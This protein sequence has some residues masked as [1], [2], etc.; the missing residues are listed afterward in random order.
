MKTNKILKVMSIIL[1]LIIITIIAFVG[2]YV[3]DNGRWENVI[4]DFTLGSEFGSQREIIFSVDDNKKDVYYDKKGNR[5]LD[6]DVDKDAKEG[7]YDIKKEDINAEDLKTTDNFIKTKEM[8][9]NRINEIGVEEYTIT[10]D[11]K[12][13]DVVLKT[14]DNTQIDTMVYGMFGKGNFAIKDAETQN[15][16]LSNE[17]LNNAKVGYFTDQTG[18][19]VYLT[20][21]LD[22]EGTT[23]LGE[24]SK[25]YIKS[26]EKVEKKDKD[27]KTTTEDKVT[28]K[29]V[30]IYIDDTLYGT[31]YFAEP[32][33]NGQLQLTL[34]T[35]MTT[36][37]EVQDALVSASIVATELNNGP[38]PLNYVVDSNENLLGSISENTVEKLMICGIVLLTA[39]L[40]YFVLKFKERAI[41]ASVLFVGYISLVSL[42]IRYAGVPITYSSAV[43]YVFIQLFVIC[44]MN[45]IL[46]KFKKYDINEIS[47]KKIIT[48]TSVKTIIILLPALIL[49]IVF[50]LFSLSVINTFG[51][52]MLWGIILFIIYLYAFIKP[53]LLNFEYLF[54]EDK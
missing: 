45:R 16:L 21:Y 31:T 11:K 12:T 15:V 14:V 23:A 32:I 27:G 30:K 24:I 47:P 52:M 26:T 13:G 41:M 25:K 3:K 35:Q 51:I 33:E 42:A 46:S 19:A 6:E 4:R 5:V 9:T 43:A 8:I 48:T 54:E 40:V 20:I 37:T 2:I 39:V 36:D 28:T 29:N 49:A 34:G 38:L 1:I 22:E 7:T 50:S 10:L 18:T 17:D 53:L 44:F